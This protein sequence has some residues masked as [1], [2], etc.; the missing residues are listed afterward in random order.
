MYYACI[1]SPPLHHRILMPIAHL[2]GVL[3]L[4]RHVHGHISSTISSLKRSFQDAS[5][6]H[7]HFVATSVLFIATI[8][9]SIESYVW[10][11]AVR[12][13]RLS[14]SCFSSCMSRCS[15]CY[16]LPGYVPWQD[17]VCLQTA[18]HQARLMLTGG[19]TLQDFGLTE[20]H[21][22]TDL[23][24][25]SLSIKQDRFAETTGPARDVHRRGIVKLYSR[26]QRSR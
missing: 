2:P 20:Y 26:V 13:S 21:V 17:G 15:V 6:T 7:F 8:V 16:I 10:P 19:M 1:T 11:H 18:V 3:E 14:S 22:G 4:V 5:K 12:G 25:V 9:M 23:R 24:Q